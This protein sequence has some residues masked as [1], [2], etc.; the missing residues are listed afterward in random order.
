MAKITQL[1][2]LAPADIDGSE[3]VPVVKAGVMR[4]SPIGALI[5]AL[6]QPFIDLSAKWASGT[7]P[8]GPGTKSS[9]EYA[10][11]SAGSASTALGAADMAHA[12]SELVA[13]TGQNYDT[14]AAATAALAGIPANAVVQVFTDESQG[15]RRALYRKTGNAL[16]FIRVMTDGPATFWVDIA[17]GSNAAGSGSYANP[18]ATIMKAVQISLPGDTIAIKPNAN[19]NVVIVKENVAA[20]AYPGRKFVGNGCFFD[21]Y[22]PFVAAWTQPDAA[23]Y[24]NVWKAPG[25]YWTVGSGG[26]AAHGQAN[27]EYTGLFAGYVP[28]AVNNTTGLQ[29]EAQILT[30]L[31]AAPDYNYSQRNGPVVGGTPSG[32][33][34]GFVWGNHDIYARLPAGIDPNGLT[35]TTQQRQQPAFGVGWTFETN[36]TVFGGWA[37]NGVELFDANTRDATI[38]VYYPSCHGSFICGLQGRLP[39]MRGRNPTGSAGYA[40]HMF[41][42][43]PK[44]RATIS[45]GGEAW[46]YNGQLDKLF[47]GH[48]SNQGNDIADALVVFDLKAT[49]CQALGAGG[50]ATPGSTYGPLTRGTFFIRPVL[51]GIKSMGIGSAACV[52]EPLIV[53][54]GTGSNG[55]CWSPPALAG[56]K[57]SVFGGSCGG[58][59]EG[60]FLRSINAPG[61]LEFFHHEA[62][63]GGDRVL[64]QWW[65]ATGTA[66]VSFT[67]CVIEGEGS[68]EF[69]NW[70]QSNTL[71]VPFT[72]S[73]ITGVTPP[74]GATFVRTQ[75]GGTAGLLRGP[76]GQV[77]GDDGIKAAASLGEEIL[78]ACWIQNASSAAYQQFHVLTQ[79]GVYVFAPNVSGQTGLVSPKWTALSGYALTGLAGVFKVNV[80]NWVIAYGKDSGGN[81]VILRYAVG[82][83]N[84]SLPAAVDLATPGLAGKTITCAVT[85]NGTDG[86]VW[87][88]CADGTIIEYDAA[89][90][91]V[92]ARASGVTYQLRGG[93][94]NG[95]TIV[96]CGSDAAGTTGT[97]GGAV[98]S[99]DTGAT[100]ANSLTA[101]DAAPAGI[102]GWAVRLT[103]AAY[104]NG[105]YFLFGA[106]GTMLT[107]TT[108][109]S[110]SWTS[111]TIKADVD[112]RHVASDPASN[113][114]LVAGYPGLG[115]D[116]RGNR[117]FMIDVSA[118]VPDAANLPITAV[119][120]PVSQVGALLVGSTAQGP[121]TNPM[122]AVCGK[123]RQVSVSEDPRAGYRKVEWPSPMRTFYTPLDQLLPS[124]LAL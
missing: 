80:G 60:L 72:D 93:T 62:L 65:S 71:T 105:L 115:Q 12:F 111:R 29:S 39:N 89:A 38:D 5:G 2:A 107:S 27:K 61:S 63:V 50:D 9:R 35:W 51:Q 74:T 82:D 99:A 52:Y 106:R 95:A 56:Q 86:K 101:T 97:V 19:G 48:G 98:V 37:H 79:K 53:H 31:Q 94:R 68:N 18:F 70:A 16:V 47:G 114:L 120:C 77:I 6:A 8:G 113:R 11:D 45:Y 100:W 55:A 66:S 7:A 54:T 122:W 13:S 10:L 20:G 90:N 26:V 118:A 3:T 123:L 121:A 43:G 22:D 83:L 34:N 104:R 112:I 116:Y 73:V 41:N 23:N 17:A 85:G 44:K 36:F 21:A 46:G 75:R 30:A 28:C 49:E 96:L 1:P 119:N 25:V 58:S 88:G 76:Q 14:K 42:G 78:G 87:F 64:G 117:M 57:V 59:R 102:G 40:W 32:T 84:N 67:N 69:T 124:L 24:P 109:L 103:R 4:R 33:T 108:G 15:G 110:G 92:Q 81:A 91:T